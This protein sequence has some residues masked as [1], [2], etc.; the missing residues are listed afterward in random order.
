MPPQVNASITRLTAASSSSSAGAGAA[1]DDW[2]EA[3][4]GQAAGAEDPADVVV[5]G[6]AEKWAGTIDA[7]LEEK[8]SRSL[9]A[10]DDVLERRILHIDAADYRELEA[11][12]ND[13]LTFTGPDGVARTA[14]I[15][16][17]AV[18]EL[19][20]IPRDLQTASLELR[21]A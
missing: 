19:D 9:A 11:D 2:D 18:A 17:I 5:V 8:I 14:T 1:R 3:M 13:V 6:G 16:A 20:G 7:F 4:A 21:A 10:G 12:T 15:A